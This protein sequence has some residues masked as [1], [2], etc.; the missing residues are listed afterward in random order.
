MLRENVGNAAMS[1]QY[2]A[3]ARALVNTKHK[4]LP[5][6]THWASV[7]GILCAWLE[8]KDAQLRIARKEAKK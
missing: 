5:Q 1:K 3:K 7:A 2:L 8:K 6:R 4:L